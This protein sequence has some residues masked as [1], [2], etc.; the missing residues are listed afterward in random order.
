MRAFKIIAVVIAVLLVLAVAGEAWRNTAFRKR[1]ASQPICVVEL[2]RLSLPSHSSTNGL[3]VSYDGLRLTVPW[4]NL[5]IT[6]ENPLFIRYQ[7]PDGWHLILQN[8]QWGSLLGNIRNS[9]DKE[10]RDLQRF[11]VGM[12]EAQFNAALL[13]VTPSKLKAFQNV[14]G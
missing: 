8:R 9:T 1:M 10:D 4:L 5:D 11:V 14:G 3:P 13:G 2:E 7:H 12:D 6:R